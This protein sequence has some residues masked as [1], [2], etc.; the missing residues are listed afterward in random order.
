ME[1]FE[2]Y[3]KLIRKAAERMEKKLENFQMVQVD[4]NATLVAIEFTQE[5]TASAITKWKG[6]MKEYI[7]RCADNS[8][9]LPK[10]GHA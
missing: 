4:Y 7:Q 10:G 8:D 5:P 6:E 1:V 9:V 2:L 3:I